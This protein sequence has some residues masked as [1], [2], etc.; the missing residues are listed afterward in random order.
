MKERI[1]MRVGDTLVLTVETK[2]KRANIDIIEVK[3]DMVLVECKSG[4]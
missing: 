4:T 2:N 1:W 3:G